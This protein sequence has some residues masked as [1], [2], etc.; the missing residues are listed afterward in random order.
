M[1]LE[2]AILTRTYRWFRVFVVSADEI[3]SLCKSGSRRNPVKFENWAMPS[4]DEDVK[5]FFAKYHP[6]FKQ[7]RK[8]SD[9][10]AGSLDDYIAIF[11]H[12]A[13]IDIPNSKDV[14]AALGASTGLGSSAPRKWPDH[15]KRPGVR[16]ER[17]PTP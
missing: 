8:L 2:C 14:A 5:G 10:I 9:V 17:F 1:R 3:S 13:L 7:P 15:R 6:Q 16:C 4:E 11:V 12:G